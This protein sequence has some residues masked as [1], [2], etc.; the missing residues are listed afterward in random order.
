MQYRKIKNL[1]IVMIMVLCLTAC[2]SN[3]LSMEEQAWNEAITYIEWFANENDADL[4]AGSIFSAD[5]V[6]KNDDLNYTCSVTVTSSDGG[7]DIWYITVEKKNN[8]D[9]DVLSVD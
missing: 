7:I 2:E 9:W 5:R 4:K 6:V 8:G 1:F 3:K